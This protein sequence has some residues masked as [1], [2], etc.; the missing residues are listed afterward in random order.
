MT[1][2]GKGCL[3]AVAGFGAI[4]GIVIVASVLSKGVERGTVIEMSISGSIEEERDESLQG[5]LM[6]GDVTLV[7]EIQ[8]LFEKAAIDEDIA[9]VM[10]TVKSFGMGR[11]KLQEVRGSIKAFRESGKWAV[12]YM[13][14]SGELGPG[15][16]PYYLASAF[17]EVTVAPSGDIMLV[18]IAANVPFLRGTLDRI[19]IYPDY[20]HIGRYKSAKDTFTEREFTEAHRESMEALVGDLYRGM[21]E[22]IAESR[23]VT[24]AEVEALVDRGP[25]TAKEAL[26]AG[27]VDKLAYFDEFR[28]AVKERNGGR[29]RTL[30]WGE[31][32][33]RRGNLGEGRHK[34]AVIHGTGVILQGRSG[35]DP[36]VG[37]LMGSDTITAAF[38]QAREDKSV[39]AIILRVDSPGGSAIASDII[40]RETQVA[41]KAG[42]PFVASMSDVAAS[43]GYYVSCGADRIIAEPTTIT[44]SIG[45]VYGKLVMK[46]LYDW[47]GLS[48]GT[49]QRGRNAGFFN[50]LTP[51]TPEE[52]EQIYWKFMR[53]IY[54]QF[55]SRVA[56]GRKMSVEDVDKIAQG[57]VWT[58]MRAKDLGLIDQLGGFPDALKAAKE[59]ANIPAEEGVRLWHLP[60]KPSLWESIFSDG[61]K[62]RVEIELPRGLRS[63]VKAFQPIGM[64]ALMAEE[65]MLL[66][67][68]GI[69]PVR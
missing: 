50:E 7:S 44:A 2:R 28:D 40:W 47:A 31:Y 8:T 51:W 49:V 42:K 27:L 37:W 23:K 55:V 53:K 12:A 45:V 63:I 54:D 56:E 68:E 32:L 6:Q 1:S 65:P 9:G 5:K 20:D 11:A 35:Y 19:G 58:G 36:S 14:S 21:V 29:L 30:K 17:D 15:N 4:I 10:V 69:V 46:G 16:G 3:L 41:R 64:M 18:G 13:D 22:D 26:D 66:A 67:P 34:I 60:E 52:K 62:A 25:F 39:K 61:P 48:F 59:L 57:R 38:R 33:K 43:G 24:P